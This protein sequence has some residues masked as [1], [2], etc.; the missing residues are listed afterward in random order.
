MAAPAANEIR[1]HAPDRPQWS[2][3][4]PVPGG[5]SEMSRSEFLRSRAAADLLGDLLAR[6]LISEVMGKEVRRDDLAPEETPEYEVDIELADPEEEL[7]AE[8]A[9]A[10]GA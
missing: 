6:A 4:S 8:L 9:E 1:L 5:S 3:L 2:E 10:S 7:A